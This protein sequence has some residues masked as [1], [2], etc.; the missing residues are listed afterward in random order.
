ML[1]RCGG[2]C[3]GAV[4]WIVH[5]KLL[6]QSDRVDPR[7]R[8]APARARARPRGVASSWILIANLGYLRYLVFASILSQVEGGCT[9]TVLSRGR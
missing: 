4:Q 9:H 1:C 7:A 8:R 2:E 6:K 3:G 5:A